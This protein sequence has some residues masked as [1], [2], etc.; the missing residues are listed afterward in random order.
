MSRNEYNFSNSTK[1]IQLQ[2]GQN[3]P[4]KAGGRYTVGFSQRGL[5]LRL[6]QEVQ[7][8]PRQYT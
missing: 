5:F 1:P 7:A 4:E 2:G 3:H 6:R 8:L